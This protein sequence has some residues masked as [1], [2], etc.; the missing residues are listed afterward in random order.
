MTTAAQE[1][2]PPSPLSHPAQGLHGLILIIDIFNIY[3]VNSPPPL[4]THLPTVMQV[5]CAD[6]HGLTI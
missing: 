5:F 6:T 2:E 4:G 1:K 3:I